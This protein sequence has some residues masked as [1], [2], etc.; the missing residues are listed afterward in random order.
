VQGSG[1]S[2]LVGHSYGSRFLADRDV[3]CLPRLR[4]VLQLDRSR[5][6][7][8]EA[9]G[10][11]TLLAVRVVSAGAPVCRRRRRWSRAPACR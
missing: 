10:A 11:L 5:R 4:A 9:S 7:L 8:A 1:L 3:A 2:E 6:M